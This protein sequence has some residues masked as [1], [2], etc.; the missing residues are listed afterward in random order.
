MDRASLAGTCTSDIISQLDTAAAS[1][2]DSIRIPGTY[3]HDE[4]QGTRIE[5]FVVSQ[6]QSITSQL[7]K[8]L[9]VRSTDFIP[10]NSQWCCVYFTSLSPVEPVLL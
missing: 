8:E 2:S 10:F 6:G 3:P 4:W 1:S 5:G 7:I 9:Q